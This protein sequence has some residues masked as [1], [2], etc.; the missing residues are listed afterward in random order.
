MQ[1]EKPFKIAGYTISEI[2][3]I[4]ANIGI[5]GGFASALGEAMRRADSTNLSRLLRSFPELIE[6]AFEHAEFERQRKEGRQS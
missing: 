2:D 5:Q 6:R 4:L 1:K 3:I